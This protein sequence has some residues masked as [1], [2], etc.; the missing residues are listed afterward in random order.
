MSIDCIFV[1]RR[2]RFGASVKPNLNAPISHIYPI[3]I[4]KAMIRGTEFCASVTDR[5]DEAKKKLA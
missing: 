2:I 3:P 4:R 5:K 1:T